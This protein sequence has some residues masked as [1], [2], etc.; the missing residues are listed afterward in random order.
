MRIIAAIILSLA[1]LAPLGTAEAA[2]YMLYR[3]EDGETTRY[4]SPDWQVRYYDEDYIYASPYR[5]VT[6][7]LHPYYRNTYYTRTA[8]QYRV[9]RPEFYKYL[10]DLYYDGRLLPVQNVQAPQSRC[11]NYTMIRTSQWSPRQFTGCQ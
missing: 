4:N 2:S 11:Y 3:P 1:T 8:P 5:S 10:E 6:H 9:T 7:A